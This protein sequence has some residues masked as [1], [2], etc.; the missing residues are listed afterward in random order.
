MCEDQWR[1]SHVGEE[2]SG[3]GSLDWVAVLLL[4]VVEEMKVLEA[5]SLAPVLQWR[6]RW[7]SRTMRGG[8][9]PPGPPRIGEM[10]PS[11]HD[12]EASDRK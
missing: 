6:L 8:T 4:L 3:L 11:K 10:A 9:L 1:A 2:L 7:G 12:C 5:G